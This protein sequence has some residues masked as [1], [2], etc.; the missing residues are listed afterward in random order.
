MPRSIYLA[1]V[2]GVVDIYYYYCYTRGCQCGCGCGDASSYV[3][4]A[5]CVCGLLHSTDVRCIYPLFK[6]GL[7]YL[8][9]CL[10]MWSN[11]LGLWGLIG[12]ILETMIRKAGGYGVRVVG[13]VRRA[14]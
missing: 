12:R 7:A 9:A 1:A 13:K 14:V 8:A 4:R 2:K 5:T 10:L 6:L 3:L 11:S